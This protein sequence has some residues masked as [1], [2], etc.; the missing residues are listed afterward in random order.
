M[1]SDQTTTLTTTN[2]PLEARHILIHAV[3]S[4]F[5]NPGP[6]GYAAVLRRMDGDNELKRKV[7]RGPE[8]TPTTNVR[9]E[10]AAAARALEAIKTGEAEPIVVHCTNSAISRG[11]SDWIHKWPA[12][13]WKG[14]DGKPVAD[15]DLWERL[16]AAS[17]GKTVEW[18]W[19]KDHLGDPRSKE[20]NKLARAE[21]ERA[22]PMLYGFAAA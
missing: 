13:G 20:V 6:G 10:M 1:N 18:R 11:M 8:A 5:G 15:Q 17:K 21:M 2:T 16:I 7:V 22:R 9:M 12:K 19:A 3:G 14:S 4:C